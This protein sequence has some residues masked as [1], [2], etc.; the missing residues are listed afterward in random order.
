[1]SQQ[2]L[3]I[4]RPTKIE[5]IRLR[6]RLRIARRLHKVLKDRLVILTQ[7]FISL[8]K[9]ALELRRIVHKSL[10][11]CDELLINSLSTTSPKDMEVLAD[12]V[13][14]YVNLV[15][16]SRVVAG[17][18]VPL[19]EIERKLD[20]DVLVTKPLNVVSTVKCYYDVIEK[21]IK[22]AEIE[23]SIYRV[24]AEVSRVKR[25]VNALEYILIPRIENTIK[26]LEMKFEERE[27]EDKTRLKKVK[28]LLQRRG[29][30]RS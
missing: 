11:K 22:L 19:I 5:L 12:N 14:H 24:G 15:V 16:G 20:N 13:Y 4:V 27:R 10:S 29:G 9:D 26:F 6:R 7:E 18:R 8:I 2:V 1:M 30:F 21:V 25:R 3:R 17:V 23:R 28:E